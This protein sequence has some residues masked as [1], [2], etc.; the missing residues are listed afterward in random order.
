MIFLFINVLIIDKIKL[1]MEFNDDFIDGNQNYVIKL[2]I[3]RIKLLYK[4][5]KKNYNC[6]KIEHKISDNKIALLYNIETEHLLDMLFGKTNEADIKCV[7]HREDVI[8]VLRIVNEKHGFYTNLQIMY[9]K[10]VGI[11]L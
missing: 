11:I 8:K 10:C 3:K 4:W 2:L 6:A 9:V 1:N 7:Q 5:E